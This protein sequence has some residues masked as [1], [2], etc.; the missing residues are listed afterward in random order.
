MKTTDYNLFEQYMLSCMTDSAHDK[1]H[2]YRVLY[3]ALDI[4]E[5]ENEVDKDILIT[6]CLLHDI[7]RQEQFEN[8]NL[9][10][11]IIGADKAYSFLIKNNYNIEFAKNVCDC[12]KS[13]RF[14][15]NNTPQSIEAKILFDADKID[16]TGTLGIARTLLYKAQVN[17]PLYSLNDNGEV[18]DGSKDTS[19]SFLQE[20]K[21]KLERL[22]SNFYTNRGT[23]IA[24]E[25]QQSAT[26]F[27][28]SMLKEISSSYKA[29]NLMD[30]ILE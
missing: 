13:H 23:E 3:T 15:E 11:A 25:R 30:Q 22:Y 9:C 2:I 1:E 21:F 7:G 5:H 27:Y 8:P 17:E 16:V 24:L 4:A 19:P 26:T 29:K 20:Y 6:A 12:I 18:C 28:D 14:R 10:H